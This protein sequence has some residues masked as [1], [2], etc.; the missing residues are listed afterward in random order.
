M[1]IYELIY[2]AF[3]NT[4]MTVLRKYITTQW[5]Y[6]RDMTSQTAGNST[7]VFKL[8]KWTSKLNIFGPSWGGIYA[9]LTIFNSII[10]II[11]IFIVV[12]S[13]IIIIIITFIVTIIIIIFS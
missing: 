3:N 12:T 2:S 13:I 4:D 7:V 8:N 5:R 10:I 6:V 1:D 9:L 11:I